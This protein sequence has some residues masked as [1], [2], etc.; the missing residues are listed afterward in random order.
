MSDLHLP[1]PASRPA[2]RGEVSNAEAL[3]GSA[4]GKG[5]HPGDRTVSG[6]FLALQE[7]VRAHDEAPRCDRKNSLALL[8]RASCF[9]LVYSTAPLNHFLKGFEGT[10]LVTDMRCKVLKRRHT[11]LQSEPMCD[12]NP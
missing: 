9:S 10:K 11:V 8:A 5:A 1:L 12:G 7:A 4:L 2:A 3:V 6:D